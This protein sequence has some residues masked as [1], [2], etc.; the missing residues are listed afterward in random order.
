M[1][2]GVYLFQ[3]GFHIRV[4]EKLNNYML[5]VKRGARTQI[6]HIKLGQN[7]AS[8]SRYGKNLRVY[9]WFLLHIFTF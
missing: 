6:S 2:Y 8:E 5:L 9:P 7:V 3:R 4:A 1:N